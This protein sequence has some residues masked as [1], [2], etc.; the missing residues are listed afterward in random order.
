M[1]NYTVYNQLLTSKVLVTEK[2]S[3]LP[4]E[5]FRVDL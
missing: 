4:R 3:P 1:D 2:T 5:S